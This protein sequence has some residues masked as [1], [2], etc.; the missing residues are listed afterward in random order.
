MLQVHIIIKL[1]VTFMV[2]HRHPIIREI[3]SFHVGKVY[4]NMFNCKY[5]LV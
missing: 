3:K 1:V 2:N 5:K 4:L